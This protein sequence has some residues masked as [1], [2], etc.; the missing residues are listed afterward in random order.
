MDS[1]DW[2]GFPM[3][4]L[5]GPGLDSVLWSSF[6]LRDRMTQRMVLKSQ[7]DPNESSQGCQVLT[8]CGTDYSTRKDKYRPKR[9]IPVQQKD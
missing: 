5:D 3:A 7:S 9:P 6:F 8:T 2:S 1:L 4:A